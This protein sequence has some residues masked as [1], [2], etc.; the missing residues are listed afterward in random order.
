MAFYK[1]KTLTVDERLERLERAYLRLYNRRYARLLRRDRMEKISYY[2]D[3]ERKIYTTMLR[4]E[5][6]N[7]KY[8][9]MVNRMANLLNARP[10]GKVAVYLTPAENAKFRYWL[11]NGFTFVRK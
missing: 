2:K 10:T 6:R 9:A 1:A 8:A 11:K 3:R 7:K 5:Q 4:N